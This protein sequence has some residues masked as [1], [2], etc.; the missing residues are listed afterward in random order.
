PSRP[1]DHPTP[2]EPTECFNLTR[3]GSKRQNC[4][5]LATERGREHLPRIRAID[6]PAE[7]DKFVYKQRNSLMA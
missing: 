3:K 4:C 5:S 6:Y 7:R 1:D 2:F